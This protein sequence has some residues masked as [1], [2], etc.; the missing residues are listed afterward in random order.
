MS[1]RTHGLGRVH[2]SDERDQQYP[3]RS[4][5]PKQAPKRHFKYYWAEG[6]KGDQGTTPQCVAYSWLHWLEDGSVTQNH[7]EPPVINPL[8]LYKDC[9]KNDYWAGEDYDGTSVRAGAKVLQRRG[10]IKEYRWTWNVDELA[11]AV[12]TIAP[13]VVG[14]NW[15]AGMDRPDEN[16]E[17]K[18]TGSVLGG[19]A[20]LI[21]GVNM[22]KRMFR[23]KNSWG[24][25]WGKK[26]HAYIS[27]DAMQRL[28]NEWGEAALAVEIKMV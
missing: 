17:L 16:F 12:L 22:K 20:Y 13:V 1:E 10:Y 24:Q 19:H 28:L 8:E 4:M 3:L 6:W 27:F 26:G 18:L 23:M 14:T 5:L 25:N 11:L 15:Y 2:V 7:K 9:Q 21:N